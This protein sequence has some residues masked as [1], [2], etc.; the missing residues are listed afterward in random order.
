MTRCAKGGDPRHR[1]PD[2]ILTARFPVWISTVHQIFIHF[3]IVSCSVA[4]NEL[5]SALLVILFSLFG[6]FFFS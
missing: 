2:S 4:L 5:I 1:I 3:A 6:C